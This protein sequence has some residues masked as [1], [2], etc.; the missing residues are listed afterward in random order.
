[1]RGHR[2]SA[3]CAAIFTLPLALPCPAGAAPKPVPGR[4]TVLPLSQGREILY[5]KQKSGYWTPNAAE[6]KNLE[7]DLPARL[8]PYYRK[9]RKARPF[10]DGMDSTSSFL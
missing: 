10:M 7:A 8:R 2:E 9:A 3:V 5:Q 4:T 6:L 1:M